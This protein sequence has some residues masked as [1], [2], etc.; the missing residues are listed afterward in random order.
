L[1]KVESWASAEASKDAFAVSRIAQGLDGWVCPEV[2]GG[3]FEPP[4]KP[5][6]TV[7]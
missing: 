5:P 6:L 4:G 3:L 1:R 7:F 2:F